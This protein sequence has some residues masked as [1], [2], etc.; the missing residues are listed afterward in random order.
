MTQTT[1]E[2]TELADFDAFF[3]ERRAVA[4]GGARMRLFGTEYQLPA[5][6]PLAYTLLAEANSDR[7]DLGALRDVLEPLFGADV[8]ERWA[9]AGMGDDDFQVVL[10]WS[11]Q[12]M[13]KPGSMSMAEAAQAVA[14]AE[15]GKAPNREARRK[16]TKA[17]PKPVRPSGSSGARS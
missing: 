9:R 4:A 13:V 16:A 8:I 17:K 7:S 11:A 3:A 6:T 5:Q 10:F 12:N 2:P 14:D 1:T 15:S